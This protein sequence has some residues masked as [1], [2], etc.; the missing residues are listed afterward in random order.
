MVLAGVSLLI[1]GKRL[2]QR[3]DADI[4]KD[5]F[6]LSLWAMGVSLVSLVTMTVNNTRDGSFLTYFILMWVWM[7]G[8]YTVIRWQKLSV[9]Y[10]TVFV[11]VLGGQDFF[12][13]SSGCRTYDRPNIQRA[14]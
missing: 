5:F 14:T 13:G 7:G 3:R 8:A 10:S 4:N 9:F 6:M 1:L 12:A 2:A 11:A